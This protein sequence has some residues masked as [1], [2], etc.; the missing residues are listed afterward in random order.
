MKSA[1]FIGGSIYDNQELL[2]IDPGYLG[3]LNTQDEATKARLLG[4]NWNVK[5]SKID[6]YD[7]YSTRDMLTNTF[8]AKTYQSASK[9]ITSDIALKGA[10]KFVV[11]GVVDDINDTGLAGNGFRAPAEGTRVETEST[12]FAVSSTSTD[13]VDT[14]GT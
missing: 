9:Y 4:G 11:G 1:T 2:K 12:E 7:Y 5:V 10:D 13:G 3:N 14:L 6:V 8:L